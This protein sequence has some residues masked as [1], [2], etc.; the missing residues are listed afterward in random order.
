MQTADVYDGVPLGADGGVVRDEVVALSTGGL[1]LYLKVILL[2]LWNR[3]A[4]L[5]CIV[6][7]R[8]HIYSHISLRAGG[9]L[10]YPFTV[11]CAR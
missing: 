1:P 10:S 6:L 8:F 11:N 9:R 2:Q 7:S 5:Y 4:A 3:D